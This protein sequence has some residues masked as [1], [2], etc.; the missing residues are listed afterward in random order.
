MTE[1][2]TQNRFEQRVDSFAHHLVVALV[3]LDM[4]APDSPLVQ[5]NLRDLVRDL[6]AIC[7]ASGETELHL[8]IDDQCLRYD[9]RTLTGA[10]LQ[11]GR[12][13]RLCR[14]RSISDLVFQ[15]GVKP[16]EVQQ[17]LYLLVDPSKRDAFF[18]RNLTAALAQ[19]GIRRINAQNSCSAIHAAVQQEANATPFPGQEAAIRQYQAMA[20]VLQTSH[21]KAYRG[22]SIDVADAASVVENAIA[23]LDEEPSHL[24]TL[25]MSDDIDQFTVGH[26]VR[27]TLLALHVAQAFGASRA[28]LTRVGT[29][30]LLHDIGKSKIPQEILFKAGRLDDEERRIMVQHARWGGELLLDHGGVDPAAIG[31]AF[32]HHMGPVG[33]GY[34]ARSPQFEPS[35]I[36][37]LVRVCDVFEALT[38]VRPYKPALN[39]VHAYVI[40]H[41]M[42]DGFDQ[43]WLR[44]FMQCIG[45]FPMGTRVIL[46]DESEAV[47]TENGDDLR[48]PVVDRL[49]GP[50]GEPLT[51]GTPMRVQTGQEVDGQVHRI[52]AVVGAGTVVDIPHELLH[53]EDGSGSCL[54]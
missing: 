13:L 28:D 15:T 27:V 38:S 9:G 51:D 33:R 31:A 41:R 3:N 4:H 26:S 18:P 47:V 8:E 42:R 52:R 30:A 1:K 44:F 36:S 2:S 10:S 11:A 43:R 17:F 49:T 22:D 48:H 34:P 46:S 19:R 12:L 53:N 50:N 32:C 40:M 37:K 7:R 23:T 14:T 39:P 16:A 29:A 54:C 35:G 25:A 45:L 21:I 5:D 20:D 6:E 24:L